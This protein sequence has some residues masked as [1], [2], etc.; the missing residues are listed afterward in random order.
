MSAE[1]RRRR[2]KTEFIRSWILVVAFLLFAIILLFLLLKPYVAAK[3]DNEIETVENC[4]V[5]P[6]VIES[7]DH[8]DGTQ[9]VAIGEVES[10]DTI[11]LIFID[12]EDTYISDEIQML[13]VLIGEETKYCPEFLMAIVEAESSGLQYSENGPCKGLMQINTD[14]P[15]I[16]E[17][18]KNHG[19]T[20]VY[21]CETNIRLG[22]YVL[23]QKR[24]I[25]G[26][27]IYAVL[28]AYN[29]SSNVSKRVENGDYTDYAVKVVNRTLELERMHGK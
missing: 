9:Q 6:K 17:Y 21:D 27:D 20:D 1:Q 8:V 7:E 15:E 14:W 23:D 26:D 18:M 4:A 13:C 10:Y 25:Y 11:N 22:C 28:M 24:E 5:Y 29:G 3:M 16:A 2:R 12:A 19:Y